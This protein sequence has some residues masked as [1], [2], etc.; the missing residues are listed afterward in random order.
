MTADCVLE[1]AINKSE[2]KARREHLMAK[3]EPN[4]VA[5]IP[6]AGEVTRSRD[7]EYAFRQD[8][9]FYYLTGFNEPDAVLVL[10]PSSEAQST[11][12]CRDKDKLAE[13][14]HGRRIGFEKAKNEYLFDATCALS[15][16]TEQL[17]DLVN[18]RTILFYTQGTYP[19]FD[20]KIWS[21]LGSLRSN[22][23]HKA[24]STI[25]DIS[26]LVHEMRLIK[27]AQEQAIMA[28][29]CK[30][31]GEA[32]IRAMEFVKPGVT[33]Y[34]LEAE[35]HHHFAMNGARHPAYG[36]IVGGGDNA[37]I[38]H[39]TENSDVLRDGDL[40]LIDSGSEYQGYAGDITRTFP[41]N[42]KFSASQTALYNIVLA[43]QLAAFN[44]VKP[45]SSLVKANRVASKILTQGLLDLGI[46]NGDLDELIATGACKEYYMHGLGHW[47]GLD[48][49]DVGDYKSQGKDR[50][51]TPGMVLTIEPGLYISQD[52]NAPAQYKGIGIRIEDN[53]LVTDTG[54][55]N[56]TAHVPK[57]IADIEA[58]MQARQDN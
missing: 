52:S 26:G 10:S 20:D 8:S 44:E 24:P 47:L 28:Q 22:R 43:A 25:K 27:S 2:F 51:F 4:S 50:E 21:L 30:I 33:E 16:L 39:Y 48:V 36:T 31:S 41:V 55:E 42:G 17:I 7:T 54:Y 53:L 58:L 18:G 29:S 56:L 40:V 23:A 38:L 1:L 37:T 57:T 32:H 46:L 35:I 15:E 6:A 34:Q 14:W 19:Q 13:V 49:H 12:F 3:M 11:L 9:D 45:G 5:I